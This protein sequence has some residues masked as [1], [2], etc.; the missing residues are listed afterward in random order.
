MYNFFKKFQDAANNLDVVVRG[1]D[2]GGITKRILKTDVEGRPEVTLNGRNV[3]LAVIEQTA[4]TTEASASFVCNQEIV[5][6][7][8]DGAYDVQF[9]LNAAIGTVGTFTVKAGQAVGP[10]PIKCTTL[11]W[12]AISGSSAFRA[13]GV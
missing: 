12:K 13:L 7:A 2:D 6:I 1:S 8:V 9:N 10:I 3:P 5:Y 4:T 11:Y